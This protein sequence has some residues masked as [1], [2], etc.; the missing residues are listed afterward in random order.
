MTSRNGSAAANVSRLNDLVVNPKFE[1]L[2][3]DNHCIDLQ[4]LFALRAT[5]NLNKLGLDPWRE[6]VQVVLGN[7]E[8]SRVCYLK[9]YHAPV[10]GTRQ[11]IA[12]SGS[13]ANSLAGVEWHW[14]NTLRS[15][16]IACPEP[17][18]FGEQLNG[19]TELRSAVLMTEVPGRSLETWL[20]ARQVDRG[21]SAPPSLPRR[22]E[23]GVSKLEADPPVSPLAKGGG[24]CTADDFRSINDVRSIRSVASAIAQ[25]VGRFHAA[26]F[27]HRDLYLSHILY[28][29]DA[30]A[31]EELHLIDL[32]RVFKPS[33]FRLRWI[34]KDLA[35][36]NFSSQSPLITRT[37]RLRWLKKYLVVAKL[38][39]DLRSLIYRIAGKTMAIARH[40][41]SRTRRLALKASAHAGT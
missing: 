33:Y 5:R 3:R 4:A 26:G 7:G 31:G 19:S 2:L 27:V 20:K 36:L 23:E 25:L 35:A 24:Y 30:A 32:Q 18:A 1:R 10:T 29:P 14:L 6:R 37:D 11:Q 12:R 38:E 28:D 40:D 41:A 21:T 9:R 22:G 13:G 15:S 16:G 8:R 39:V 17:I 34:I